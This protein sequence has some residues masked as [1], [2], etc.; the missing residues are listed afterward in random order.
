VYIDGY[1]WYHAVFK[2]N[3][4]WK[5]L[6]VQTFFEPIRPDDDVTA[7]KLFTAMVVDPDGKER[8][9]TY[10]NALDTLPKISIKYGLFQPRQVTCRA[11]CREPYSV[12][13]EKKTDVNMAVAM[14]S[15]AVDG[16]VDRMCVVTGDS[17]IQPAIEWISTRFPN[18]RTIIYV[19]CLKRDQPNRRTDHYR[20]LPRVACGFLPIENLGEHQLKPNVKIR[21]NPI[22][23]ACRPASWA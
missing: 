13:E 16:L 11:S 7:I 18:I 9:T 23:F 20:Y 5:W 4:Q 2:E 19:P 12:Q 14:I 15:D 21:E 17:D 22:L 6:N 8:Q 10:F 1:N 3:P